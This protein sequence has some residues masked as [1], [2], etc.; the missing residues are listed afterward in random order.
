MSIIDHQSIYIV[1]NLSLIHISLMA[2]HGADSAYRHDP[3]PSR[4]RPC[5]PW[6]SLSSSEGSAY[7]PY[8]CRPRKRYALT[9]ILMSAGL[10]K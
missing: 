1:K 7:S 6:N 5:S 2:L 8:G 9:T 3:V 4:Y 10:P